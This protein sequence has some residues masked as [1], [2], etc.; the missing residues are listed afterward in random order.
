MLMHSRTIRIKEQNPKGKIQ[1]EKHFIYLLFFLD[2]LV[3]FN[4][5]RHEVGLKEQ[6]KPITKP[7]GSNPYLS[8]QSDSPVQ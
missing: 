2:L 7:S 4:F 1:R 5:K 8:N 6:V 3:L